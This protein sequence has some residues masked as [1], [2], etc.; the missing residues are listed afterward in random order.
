LRRLARD[1]DRRIVGAA[2]AAHSASLGGRSPSNDGEVDAGKLVNVEGQCAPSF[3]YVDMPRSS[4]SYL[5]R[6]GADEQV[7]SF[8]DPTGA[9][10]FCLWY[11]IHH[12]FPRVRFLPCLR[13]LPIEFFDS[14]SSPSTLAYLYTSCSLGRAGDRDLA[15][16]HVGHGS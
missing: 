3:K 5:K 6:M 13:F 9:Q 14:P 1:Y 11:P 10:G 12:L 4:P 15:T 2:V 8:L 16:A 7:H